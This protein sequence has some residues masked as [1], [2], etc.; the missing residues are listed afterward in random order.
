V[1]FS[2]YV[3]HY[4]FLKTMGHALATKEWLNMFIESKQII[5]T[6]REAEVSQ[7]LKKV[8]ENE[9]AIVLDAPFVYVQ[10]NGQIIDK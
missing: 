5:V 3:F 6:G 1:N 2:E 7:E 9:E 10:I 8:F 4:L